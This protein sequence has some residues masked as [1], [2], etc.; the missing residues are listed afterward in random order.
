MTAT[1]CNNFTIYNPS[2][3]W[4]A[5]S[6]KLSVHMVYI[7]LHTLVITRGTRWPITFREP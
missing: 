6:L 7:E 5:I 4:I 2:T 1:G 3:P